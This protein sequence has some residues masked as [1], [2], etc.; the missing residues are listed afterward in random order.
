MTTTP[1]PQRET[2]R[3]LYTGRVQGVGFRFTTREIARLHPVTG[4]VRNLPDGR[5]EVVV[6]GDPDAIRR[7]L[8]AVAKRF[9]WNIRQTDEMPIGDDTDYRTFEI[10]R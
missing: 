4:F 8:D 10:R 1:S 3:V 6:K 9:K 7:F 5:V 2:K